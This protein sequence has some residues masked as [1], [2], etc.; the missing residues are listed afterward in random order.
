LNALHNGRSSGFSLIELLIAIVILGILAGLAMPSF[1]IWLQNSQ[2]R[3]AAES[4]QNGLQHARTEAVSRNAT[5]E[6]VLGTGSSWAVNV[7]GGASNPIDSRSSAEGSR[8]VTATVTPAGAT[9]VTFNNFGGLT[10][11]ADSSVTLTQVELDSAVLAPAD[12][13][14]LRVTIGLGGNVRMCDPN[15]PATSPTAC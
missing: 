10:T 1:N 12:S 5:V 2:I 13:R 11:N 8:N 3:N 15:A 7:I 4:I 9:T 14:E 6:F